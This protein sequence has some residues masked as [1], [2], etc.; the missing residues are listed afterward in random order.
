MP[1]QLFTD[2]LNEIFK[3]LEDEST[4]HSCLLVNM[5]FLFKSYEKYLNFNT[6][7]ACLPNDP[8][9]FYI[10]AQ[11][12]L[13]YLSKYRLTEYKDLTGTIFSLRSPIL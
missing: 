7:I 4:L 9:E 6:L 3:Y 10:R 2:C 12:N 5:K 13:K 8:I 11:K 1:H